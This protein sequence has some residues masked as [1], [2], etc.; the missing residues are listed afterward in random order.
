METGLAIAALLLL[1]FLC[2]WLAWRV[3]LPA[4]LFQLLC[5]LILGPVTGL[6]DPDRSLRVQQFPLV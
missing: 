3:R 5:G 2:Q 1:G 6:L 4:I